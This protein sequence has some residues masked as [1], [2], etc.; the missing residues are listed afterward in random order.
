MRRPSRTWTLKIVFCFLAGAVVTWAVAWGC[1]LWARYPNRPP[2]SYNW[3]R[4]EAWP[5][6]VPSDWPEPQAVDAL[7]NPLVDSNVFWRNLAGGQYGVTEVRFGWPVRAMSWVHFYRDDGDRAIWWDEGL[8]LET[9]RGR[10]LPLRVLPLG[11]MLNTLLAAAVL[12]GMV[13]GAGIARRRLRAHRGRCPRCNYDR[14][15]IAGDA[16]CPECGAA[17]QG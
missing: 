1:A 14:A 8:R 7:T 13:E 10:L 11:F 12:M 2:G 3:P 4:P 9:L 17:S 16:L 15:G 5:V 6:P